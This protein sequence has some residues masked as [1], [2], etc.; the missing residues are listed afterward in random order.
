MNTSGYF[1][2]VV[3]VLLTISAPLSSLSAQSLKVGILRYKTTEAV[4]ATF[5]PLLTHIAQSQGKTLELTIIEDQSLAYRLHEG[6]FDLGIFKPFAYLTA[7]E[8]FPDLSV[9]A[10][11]V[12]AGATK[13]EGAILTRKDANIKTLADFNGKPFTFVKQTS[14]SGFTYP[15]SIFMEYGMDI[16]TLFSTYTFS[17]SHVKAL[18][19][20]LSG[21]TSGIAIDVQGLEEFSQEDQEQLQI[22]KMYEVP[23][24]AYVFSSKVPEEQQAQ[25]LESMLNAYR[26]PNLKTAFDN[27][28]G[29]ENFAAASDADYNSLRRYLGMARIKPS[30]SL[31]IKLREAAQEALEAKGDVIPL[32]KESM[33]N[34]L[35]RTER[36][37]SVEMVGEQSADIPLEMRISM[38]GEIFHYVLYVHGNQIS[39]GDVALKALQYRLPEQI[40]IQVLMHLP[41]HTTLLYSGDRWFINYGEDDGIHTDRYDFVLELGEDKELTLGENDIQSLTAHSVTFDSQPEFT[42]LAPM[43]ITYRGNPE[44]RALAI[45]IQEQNEQETGFWSKLDNIWGV[46]GLIVAFISSAVGSFFSGRKKK[47]FRSMLH[48]SNLL[49]REYIADQTRIDNKIVLMQEKI[50]ES[51]SKGYVDENQFLI[52]KQRLED[53]DNV[54]RN[55]MVRQEPM[56]G[57]V[58]KEIA[59]ILESDVISERQFTRII[60]LVKKAEG[61]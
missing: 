10:T 13:Y 31:E 50:N 37:A 59:K 55:F 26:V 44:A 49:L 19:S 39:E 8:Q 46:I 7:K 48:E 17:G 21:K 3:A 9:S 16:D 60:S 15:R 23:H 29:V 61:K 43:R 41:I 4:E 28:L 45:N 14:T 25:L 57:E 5:R 47:R 6:E 51:L 33:L 30:L 34:A 2:F 54:I 36:F 56:P 32:L 40:A 52:L 38:I 42:Y 12:V 24:P 27:P 58:S 18:T 1:Q 35:Q 53:I 11:H 22:L 20:L